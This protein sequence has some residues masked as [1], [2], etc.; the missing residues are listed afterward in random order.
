MSVEPRPDAST[1]APWD[2]APRPN[3]SASGPEDVRM[4]CTVTIFFAPVTW[5]NAA[6]IASATSSSS[7]SGTTPLMSYAFT[8]LARSPIPPPVQLALLTSL[9]V[10][11]RSGL[12]HPEV[13]TPTD[14]DAL[15]DGLPGTLPRPVVHHRVGQRL[16]VIGAG[17][18]R[19]LERQPDHIPATRRGQPAGM[20]LAQVIAVRLRGRG[21]RAEHRRGVPVHVRQ[22]VYR[23]ILARGAR[24][25]TGT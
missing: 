4:S 17:L 8:I 24:A 20:L 15:A 23:Q 1:S 21:Q 13:A 2:A 3:A 9:S 14:L 12:Q 11:G 19:L 5:T 6:P 25:A 16:Q 7:W 10:F 18:G 22:C